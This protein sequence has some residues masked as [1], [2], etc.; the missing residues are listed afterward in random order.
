MVSVT[1]GEIFTRKMDDLSKKVRFATVDVGFMGDA[2]ERKT[3]I[4]T[5]LVAI[6]NEYGVPA[7]HQ[8]PRPFFRG[9]INA[10]Q[11]EWPALIA[12]N[13]VDNDY[14]TH[15]TMDE[16]GKHVAD[17][18]Q[19]AILTYVGPPLAASTVARKGF[20]KQLIDTSD[21]INSIRHVMRDEA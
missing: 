8:P 5:A 9:M 6:F 18:L 16:L 17:Q 2:T 12:K 21:M 4:S 3:G 19:D 20:D 15:K 10:H 7:H 11:A 14:D 13:L 1:G